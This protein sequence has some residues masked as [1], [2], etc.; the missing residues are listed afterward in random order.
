VR[1]IQQA[2]SEQQEGVR[3]IL[4]ALKSMNDITAQVKLGSQEMH[5]GNAMVSTR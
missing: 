5:T 2:M 3:Q 4:D 1:Q